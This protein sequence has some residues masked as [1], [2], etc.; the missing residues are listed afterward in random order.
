[1]AGIAAS[2]GRGGPQLMEPAA[3][4][5][6]RRMTIA[7]LAS[8]DLV[9]FSA[10]ALDDVEMAR[11]EKLGRPAFLVIPNP[12][13]RQDAQAWKTRYPAIRVV[14]PERARSAVDEVVRVD[15][16]VGDFGDSGVRFVPVAGTKG[17]SAL[18][19]QHQSSATLVINDLI[20]NVQD[21]RGVMKLVLTLMG[22]AGGHPQV[23][24]MFRKRAVENADLVAQQFR[25]W[26]ELPGLA[27][28]IVSHGT[29]IED[30]PARLLHRLA[31]ELS[32]RR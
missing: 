32:S 12:F 5:L 21:A 13:H 10:I 20:A 29:I 11:V 30:A 28:I 7:R 18:V 19:V 23:P 25:E 24:R 16:T 2:I 6:P 9:V 15:D 3:G 31:D 4:P 27:R 1:M 26:A 8:G 17:E 22:F 14:A